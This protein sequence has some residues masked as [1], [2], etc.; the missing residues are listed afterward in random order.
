[1]NDH[2]IQLVRETF[3]LL[4]PIAPQAAA[5][6]YANVFAADPSLTPLFKGDMA[7]QGD[8]LMNTLAMAV[9]RLD[10]P[11]VLVPVLRG[12]GQRHAGLG[13]RDEHYATFGVALL[14]TLRHDLGVA[15]TPEVE[16]AWAQVYG[17]AA[18]T[19]QEAARARV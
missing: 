8:R 11:E 4:E 3:D 13:V 12:L 6:F 2:S 1:M 10:E 7:S 5:L 19:M 9:G 16:E 17:A 15:F 14:S 18:G